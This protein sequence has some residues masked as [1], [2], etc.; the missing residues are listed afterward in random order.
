MFIPLDGR[1]ASSNSIFG[2]RGDFTLSGS[3]HVNSIAPILEAVQANGICQK[4]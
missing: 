3:F 4:P 2:R 1:H